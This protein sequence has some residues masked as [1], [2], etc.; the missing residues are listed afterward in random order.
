MYNVVFSSPASRNFF[1]SDI[2]YVVLYYLAL[3][4]LL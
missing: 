4:E 1:E 2:H 3:V